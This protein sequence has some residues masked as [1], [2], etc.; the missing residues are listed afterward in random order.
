M[1]RRRGL[2]GVRHAGARRR[3][4]RPDPWRRAR[5]GL[6]LFVGV[7]LIG[8]C[9]YSAIGLSPFDALY[10]TAI[11]VTTVGY[12]E[13]GAHVP[14]V[15]IVHYRLFTLVLVL[16]G[17]GSAIYTISM[18]IETV[19]EFNADDGFRRRR[20][21]R[22]INDMNDHVIIA[23]WGRVG[24]AIA[25]YVRRH[26]RD[27]VVID[28]AP[29]IAA[30]DPPV[31]V[32]DANEDDVLREAGIERAAVLIAA[33]NSD[34]ENLS[35]T[36]TARS[37]RED[38]F[39]VARTSAQHNERKFFQA[40]ANRVVNPHHIGGSRMAALALQPNVAEFLDE[41]LDDPEHD[42]AIHEIHVSAGSPCDGCTVDEATRGDE[43]PVLIAVRRT[44]GRYMANP[45][46]ELELGAGD[47]LIALG[48]EQQLA[49]L[50]AAAR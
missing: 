40:G 50:R 17:A 30:D 14:D 9:G 7:L 10:Q 44:H 32:G 41:V 11:T 38:I 24:R 35:L 22:T 3:T 1:T 36:L 23:G 31:V 16:L 49:A 26:D 15:D 21:R 34:A 42:V 43:R 13:I 19:V 37:L 46:A 28:L 29:K 20:M 2:F 33:L 6:E 4:G 18:V 5:R 25:D 45:P 48:S 12:G 39:L 8:T 27:V 47:V